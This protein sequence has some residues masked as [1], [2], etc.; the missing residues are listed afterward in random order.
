MIHVS[1]FLNARRL[2][3]NWSFC[4]SDRNRAGATRLS[5]RGSKRQHNRGVYVRAGID[6]RRLF[7][8]S[9]PSVLPAPQCGT[10]AARKA[11]AAVASSPER[12]LSLRASIAA[13]NGP[14][15]QSGRRPTLCW[16]TRSQ[17]MCRSN[18]RGYRREADSVEVPT[19]PIFGA[20]GTRISAGASVAA[21]L[22]DGFAGGIRQTAPV[23]LQTF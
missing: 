20:G 15:Q 16:P 14:S 19:R 4:P 9:T 17:V 10:L 21:S 23:F 22:L 6:F 2:A 5:E 12:G 8:C 1:S 7:S 18:N 11:I 13:L 3:V